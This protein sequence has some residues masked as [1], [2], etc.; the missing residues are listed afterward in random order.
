MVVSKP[1]TQLATAARLRKRAQRSE[2]RERPAF[3]KASARSRRS[4]SRGGG[5]EPTKR[6]ARERVEESEGRCPS[7]ES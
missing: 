1:S 6:L 4:A 7:E 3:A 2:P 5:S